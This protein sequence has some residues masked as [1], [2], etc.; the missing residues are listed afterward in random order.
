MEDRVDHTRKPSWRTRLFNTGLRRV[1][2]RTSRYDIAASR[3]FLRRVDRL[4]RVPRDIDL[5]DDD[6][7]GVQ[8][9]WIVAPGSAE[10]RVILYLH[11]G[12][13]C[14]GGSLLHKK[15]VAKL[16]RLSGFRAFMP[17]YR[18]APEYPYPAGLDDCVASYRWLLRS[19]YAPGKIV[20]AG[21]S[22]ASGR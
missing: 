22:S 17:F 15:M 19:G 13:F 6:S 12:G 7:A 10:E 4:F 8:G 21:E 16:C 5:I 1:K 20:I 11:G 2:E 18:L 14:L 9:Q 3:D